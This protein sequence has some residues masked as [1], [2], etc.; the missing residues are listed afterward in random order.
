MA[1]EATPP[2]VPVTIITGFL[3]AGKTTLLNYIL[4]ADH[5]KRICVIENEFGEDIGVEA[6]VAKD[7]AG[8]SV[9]E[10]F[11]E[12]SNGCL[13]CTVRDDLVETL[14]RVLQ[15]R[16]RYDYI[17]V[18]TTGMA[19]PGPVATAFWQDDAL[20]SAMRLDGIVTV[21]DCKLLAGQLDRVRV[22]GGVNEAQRQ[23]AH[24]DVVI[25]NKTDL[26]SPA[27]RD[28]VR[29]RV[30]SINPTCVAIEA[31]RAVVSLDRLLD[32][33]A[34][35]ASRL[36]DQLLRGPT[37]AAQ[38]AEPASSPPC[39]ARDHGHDHH[40][41]SAHCGCGVAARNEHGR[42]G[43]DEVMTVVVEVAGALDERLLTKFIGS[44]VWEDEGAPD[45]DRSMLTVGSQAPVLPASGSS[46]AAPRAGPLAA[47][48]ASGSGGAGGNVETAAAA[49]AAAA[50][51][52]DDDDDDDDP[53]LLAEPT[54]ADAA[55]AAAG[56]AAAGT[57]AAAART[58]CRED[59]MDILRIKGVVA[60]ADPGTGSAHRCK[61]VLQGVEDVFEVRETSEPWGSSEQL[62]KV[63]FIGM[64]LNKDRL[65]EGLRQCVAV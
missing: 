49:A 28:A 51:A 16:D 15:R 65:A 32:L 23:I 29:A 24:A 2:R 7:G 56:T 14:E 33:E 57:A 5:G 17:I 37:P 20:E 31:E 26:V 35:S 27:G 3:G 19:N 43:A 6:L 8:G 12:L 48:E 61:H 18:E 10:D 13:C 45:R 39:S 47:P 60:V 54:E 30:A 21:A 1:A 50:A 62:S 22:D 4:T 53:P 11:F 38:S 59:A 46:G 40:D 63:L 41:H 44:V 64:N 34:F 9:V 25:L 58:R 55:A 52:N 42:S 36:Q